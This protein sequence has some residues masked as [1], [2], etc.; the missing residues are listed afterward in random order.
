MS[1]NLQ[2]TELLNRI[3]KIIELINSAYEYS[4]QRGLLGYYF[5]M[6][7]YKKVDCAVEEYN[8]YI[9]EL[10]DNSVKDEIEIIRNFI[11]ETMPLTTKR[12]DRLNGP[13]KTPAESE[14]VADLWEETK[15]IIDKLT[16]LNKPNE[17][18]V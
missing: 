10:I 11:I 9:K 15:V 2:T 5:K 8:S 18:D 17:V 16:L 1:L 14:D 7:R 3:Q 4:D 12:P 6:R 13:F